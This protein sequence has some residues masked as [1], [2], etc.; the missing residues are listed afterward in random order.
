MG[1]E[2]DVIEKDL[3]ADESFIA[4]LTYV[5]TICNE[6]EVPSN[7][8]K[9][10]DTSGIHSEHQKHDDTSLTSDGALLVGTFSINS[11]SIATTSDGTNHALTALTNLYVNG[12]II[13]YKTSTIFA[14]PSFK[15]V[16]QLSEEAWREANRFI[17][18]EG[19]FATSSHSR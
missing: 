9:I 8:N 6:L 13:T 1:T 7:E 11:P 4:A 15:L 10:A 2:L 17:P 18:K 5:P 14:E 3:A 12:E 19:K 16:Q